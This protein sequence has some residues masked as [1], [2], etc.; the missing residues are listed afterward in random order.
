MSLS[1]P[2]H[3]DMSLSLDHL[4]FGNGYGMKTPACDGVL[5]WLSGRLYTWIGG[6]G[7]QLRST[8]WTH[9][10]PGERRTL[11]GYRFVVF[12]SSRRWIRVETSWALVELPDK[13]EDANE[14]IR[15]LKKCLLEL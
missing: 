3:N 9:P 12:N 14:K 11:A 8:Q 1:R 2:G 13:L 15:A 4:I 6:L 5:F 7:A 10:K